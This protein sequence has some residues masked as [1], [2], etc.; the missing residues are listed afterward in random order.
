LHDLMRAIRHESPL[1]VGGDRLMPL[2]E[3]TDLLIDHYGQR[4][5]W[6]GRVAQGYV[7]DILKDAFPATVV[8][9]RLS[10]FRLL[11]K[12]RDDLVRLSSQWT[13][14]DAD[15]V[16]VILEKLE[17][18]SKALSLRVPAEESD[19]YLLEMVAMLT[20]MAANFYHSGRLSA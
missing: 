6:Y 12:N 1:V 5:S 18:R 10:V 8:G 11:R 2:S 9:Q 14:L 20:G 19:R 4:S 17:E 7:D 3:M 15:E 13:G 16:R